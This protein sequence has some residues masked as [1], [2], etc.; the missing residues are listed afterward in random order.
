MRMLKDII[1]SLPAILLLPAGVCLA[2]LFLGAAVGSAGAPPEKIPVVPEAPYYRY[3]AYESLAILWVG[4][5]GLLVVIRMKL[6]EIE[7]IQEME[8]HRED[9]DAPLLK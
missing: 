4:I 8:L 2:S 7:R 1:R 5:L 6:K 9:P 3:I